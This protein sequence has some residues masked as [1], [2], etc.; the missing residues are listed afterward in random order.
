MI[1]VDNSRHLFSAQRIVCVT[2]YHN[3]LA[4]LMHFVR[5][6]SKSK[7]KHNERKKVISI[8][9]HF[10]ATKQQEIDLSFEE[11][12][13]KAEKNPKNYTQQ[14][15]MKAR[16]EQQQ[17]QRREN[18]R[19]WQ[20]NRHTKQCRRRRQRPFNERMNEWT[21]KTRRRKKII[22]SKYKDSHTRT[23]SIKGG[24]GNEISI[25]KPNSITKSQ[26]RKNVRA[27]GRPGEE[28]QI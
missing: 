4:V 5:I 25:S 12:N 26:T 27:R 23:Q 7:I 1:S 17:Q 2:F 22:E 13:I 3:T 10:A 15:R 11:G 28:R 6:K 24:K 21:K 18:E 8:K 14:A 20:E 19:I 16:S 9:L